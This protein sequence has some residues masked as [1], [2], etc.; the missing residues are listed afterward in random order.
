MSTLIPVLFGKVE[1][2]L[3]L[4]PGSTP[5][6]AYS[7]K[8]FNES[9]EAGDIWSDVSR[10]WWHIFLAFTMAEAAGLTSLY[11]LRD[12]E[13]L[14]IASPDL[15]AVISA[16]DQLLRDIDHD[17]P[18]DIDDALKRYAVVVRVPEYLAELPNIT[19][20]SENS[21]ASDEVADFSKRDRLDALSFYSFLVS[22]RSIA[23][24]ARNDGKTFLFI[25]PPP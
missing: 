25:T 2:T 20:V 9:F 6:D 14:T 21:D 7:S 5:E 12:D 13:C 24:S 22:L 23:E 1:A 19:P 18:N 10:N 4:P 16:L 15:P 3:V 17:L 8:E 11:F